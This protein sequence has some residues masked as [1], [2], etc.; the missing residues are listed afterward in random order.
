MFTN[1]TF[2]GNSAA[3]G[4]GGAIYTGM[5]CKVINCTFTGNRAFNGG[6][7]YGHNGGKMYTLINTIC[8]NNI[9]ENETGDIRRNNGDFTI[10]NC[11]A[12]VVSPALAENFDSNGNILTTPAMK[13]FENDAAPELKDNGGNTLTVALHAT[14]SMAAKAGT[15]TAPAGIDVTIPTVDQRG[16][17]RAA[18]PC[19]G[20]FELGGIEP[21]GIQTATADAKF[22]YSVEKGRLVIAESCECRIFNTLGAKIT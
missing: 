19:M 5:D 22:N 21:V 1:R 16:Y 11:L 9:D 10:Y 17:T 18:K 2:Y 7:F 4:R 3:L 20:A 12:T 6:G 13:V 15:A 8:Y 14:Q